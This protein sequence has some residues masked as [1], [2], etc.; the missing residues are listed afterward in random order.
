MHRPPLL[1]R[2]LFLSDLHLGSR[3]CQADRILSLL[4]RCQC[5]Q[6]YLVGDIIDFWAQKKQRY[7]PASHHQ[8]LRKL[9]KL[10]AQ[11]V[12]ITYLPGNHDG[13]LREFC[14]GELLGIRMRRRQVHRTLKGE[15][16]LITHG[17]EFDSA[18]LL[19][20]LHR[21]MGQHGYETLLWLNRVWNRYRAWRGKGH[22][23]LAKHLK[24]RLKGANDAVARYRQAAVDEARRQGVEGIVCGHIHCPDQRSQDGVQY[25][26]TGDW[27]ESF[28]AITED[29]DGNMRL[30]QLEEAVNPTL[31]Q[32]A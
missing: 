25:L 29:L 20:R 6:I 17:D 13:V 10:A 27:L 26:N 9:A 2:S 24:S 5:Q 22:W 1:C 19:C 21:L 11:G 30:V 15:H 12:E 16:F 3:A 8:V 7:W 4:N 28:T 31:S 32:V 18:V 23:S 14:Q